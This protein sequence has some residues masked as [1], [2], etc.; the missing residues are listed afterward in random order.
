MLR[1]EFPVQINKTLNVEEGIEN[2]FNKQDTVNME[3][4]RFFTHESQ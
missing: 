4:L 2:P 1:A 3:R